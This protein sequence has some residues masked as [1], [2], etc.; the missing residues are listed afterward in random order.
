[1]FAAL[2]YERTGICV[3]PQKRTLLSNR[4]RRRLRDDG[5]AQTSATTTSTSRGFPPTT[6]NGTPSSRESPPTK[7][8][9]SATS[10]IGAGF[11]ATSSPSPGAGRGSARGALVADLVGRRQHRRRALHRRCCIASC[12]P[13]SLPVE[14]PI[15]GTDIGV[16]ALQQARAA[17]F[18]P[19]AM[20]LVPA[21][22][23]RA[24]FT[25]IP[26]PRRGGPAAADR[27]D[28]LPAAQPPGR[29]A[30]RPLTWSC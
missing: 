30:Q 22:Y 13:G 18:G 28:R 8:I 6:R 17:A 29:P 21:D 19:R 5:I 4:L 9:P 7:P 3:S 25:E 27:H 26:P 20:R 14:R 24:F 11:A 1:M 23:R 12:L 10:R 15:L 2:I 16:G